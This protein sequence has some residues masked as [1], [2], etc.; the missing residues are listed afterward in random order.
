MENCNIKP[1]T[2]QRNFLEVTGN[3]VIIMQE[4]LYQGL[5]I[6]SCCVDVSAIKNALLKH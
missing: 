6:N 1:I 5:S 3:R 2:L 4:N